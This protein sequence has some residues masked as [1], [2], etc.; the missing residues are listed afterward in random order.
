MVKDCSGNLASA[1]RLLVANFTSDTTSPELVFFNLDLDEG[2]LIALFIEPMD[3]SVISLTEIVQQNAAAAPTEFNALTDGTVLSLNDQE[4]TISLASEY[5]MYL[6]VSHDIASGLETTFLSLTSLAIQ[7]TSG[8]PVVSISPDN[9]I[10]VTSFSPD[11]PD[12]IL[13]ENQGVTFITI[14]WSVP[15]G[16][17]I[18]S[19]TVAWER[20][21][22]PKR[23]D[24]HIGSI[25]LSSEQT[26]VT[27]SGTEE[28]SSYLVTVT[29]VNTD[30]DAVSDPITAITLD[31]GIVILLFETE[32]KFTAM[33]FSHFYSSICPS[34]FS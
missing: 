25:L 7:D 33:F 1:A 8:N 32:N 18:L 27:L 14:S 10:R 3:V 12:I 13:S 17:V 26:N 31:T 9:A 20:E 16:P 19:Y 5:L 11:S 2:K 15:I 28:G 24:S 21:T 23:P 29:G 6:Q 30:I 34:N 22:T 4:V